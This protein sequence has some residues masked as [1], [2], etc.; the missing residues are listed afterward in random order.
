MRNRA[1][2]RAFG[3]CAHRIRMNKLVVQRSFGESINHGLVDKNPVRY[4]DFATDKAFYV[5]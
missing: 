4:A 1:A 5:F 2:E 3:C